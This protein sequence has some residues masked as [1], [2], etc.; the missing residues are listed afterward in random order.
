[1]RQHYSGSEG[2][3]VREWRLSYNELI[4]P[5]I[6][7]IDAKILS[8]IFTNFPLNGPVQVFSWIEPTKK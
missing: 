3:K 4:P 5:L 2:K 1:M 8:I 6:M 7:L